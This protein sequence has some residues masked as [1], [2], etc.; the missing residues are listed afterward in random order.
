MFFCIY[1]DQFVKNLVTIA[2][3]NHHFFL[4][5]SETANRCKR[6]WNFLVQHIFQLHDIYEWNIL[7]LD[8]VIYFL[9]NFWLNVL[10]SNNRLPCKSYV[11]G[12]VSFEGTE[13]FF[14][15]LVMQLILVRFLKLLIDMDD[16]FLLWLAM[17]TTYLCTNYRT[18][19]GSE[20]MPDA[21]RKIFFKILHLFKE[22]YYRKWESTWSMRKRNLTVRAE[23]NHSLGLKIFSLGLRLWAF[24]AGALGY[25]LVCITHFCIWLTLLLKN[26]APV[27]LYF[28]NRL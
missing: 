2:I 24:V 13:Y 4:F 14:L 1:Y 12:T 15:A 21:F 5:M 11:T 16:L 22:K 7:K 17:I 23:T 26:E 25:F 27:P 10:C 18:L 6:T 8:E 19:Y 28:P 9:Y 20:W 3:V